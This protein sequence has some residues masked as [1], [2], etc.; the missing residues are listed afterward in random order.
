[1]KDINLTL[2]QAY[3]EKLNG[4]V[5]VQYSSGS[6]IA[7][8]TYNMFVPG[9]FPSMYIVIQS[10]SSI[11]IETKTS[12]DRETSIQ[13]LVSTRLERNSGWECDQIADQIYQI[14]YPDRSSIIPGCLSMD[15]VSDVTIP[16][17]D[18]TGRL[19][20]IERAITFKHIITN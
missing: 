4:H 12:Q 5:N 9:G 7:V 10:I 3:Y 16:D 13:F 14:C 11:G 17:V 20:I 2:R 19:Q 15:L 18:E 1:L 6:P 8:P